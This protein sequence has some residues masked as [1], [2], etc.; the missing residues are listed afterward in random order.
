MTTRQTWRALAAIAGLF[1]AV[2]GCSNV[3]RAQEGVNDVRT[4]ASF[5]RST[6]LDVAAS[7]PLNPTS[8]S[9]EADSARGKLQAV[10]ES[11]ERILSVADRISVALTG[12]IDKESGWVT[13]LK[14]YWWIVGLVVLMVFLT[15]SGGWTIVRSALSWVGVLIP[16]ATRLQ[17]EAGVAMLD[18]TD[19]V[20]PREAIAVRRASDPIYNKAFEKAQQAQILKRAKAAKVTQ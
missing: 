3:Q 13:I 14:R 15:F 1:A 9:P 5:S 2:G 20:T 16:K 10:A 6:V 12:T 4:E 17:A 7:P 19:P 8:P 11:Q 18:P